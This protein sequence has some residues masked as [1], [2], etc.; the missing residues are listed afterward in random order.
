MNHRDGSFQGAHGQ[1]IY[2]RYWTPGSASRGVMLVVHGAGEHGDR[3]AY[4]AQRCCDAG[5]AVAALDHAGHGRSDG[6]YGHM[7]RFQD[8]LENL[9]AFREQVVQD[10]PG[11]PLVLVGHSMGGLIS[12]CYLPQHQ[13]H[14]AACVLSGP[15]IKTELEP[16][17]VQTTLIRLLSVLAPRM[18][19]LQ[20]DA[21]GVSRDAAV[22]GAYRQD[23][24]VNHGKM[25]ARFVSELFNAMGRIQAEAPA[26]ELPLLVMH[27]ESDAMTA[28]SG[29]QFLHDK[30]SS[31]DKTLKL[32][33]GLYHEIFNEPERDAVI[34]D[35]LAWLD[36]RLG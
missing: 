11:Q 8:H 19:V 25:S 26:I 31:R 9:D 1:S 14:F 3:Y 5:L 28:P 32:Y 35:L 27:G 4:F 30:V 23:P 7:A 21:A 18:G 6:D 22:V 33:P 15:A 24:L 34:D 29:S 2:Y 20:L 17:F 36:T 12:A 13:A 10:F 16:G